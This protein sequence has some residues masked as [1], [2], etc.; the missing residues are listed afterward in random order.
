M[1]KNHRPQNN[2]NQTKTAEI[3]FSM[4]VGPVVAVIAVLGGCLPRKSENLS[5]QCFSAGTI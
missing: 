2:E 3:S 5:F 1:L 4:R